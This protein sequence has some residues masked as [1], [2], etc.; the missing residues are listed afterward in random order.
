MI[1][2]CKVRQKRLQVVNLIQYHI[3]L[4]IFVLAS[5]RKMLGMTLHTKCMELSV[6]TFQRTTISFTI[7]DLGRDCYYV[8]L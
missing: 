7:P 6:K 1:F 8:Y 3:I 2:T 5:R 4:E